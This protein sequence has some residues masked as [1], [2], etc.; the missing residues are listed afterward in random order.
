MMASTP[1]ERDARISD[2]LIP[3]FS[4]TENQRWLR[5]AAARLREIEAKE[6]EDA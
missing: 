4:E 1:T 6:R 5:L 2:A 3:T